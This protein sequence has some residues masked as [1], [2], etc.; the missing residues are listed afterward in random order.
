M[1]IYFNKLPQLW[2]TLGYRIVFK[3]YSEFAPCVSTG[4]HE[5]AR[6]GAGG[7]MLKC[8]AFQGVIRDVQHFL[9]HNWG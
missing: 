5:C 3:R 7:H 4:G 6:R 8:S 9:I 1:S 2:I